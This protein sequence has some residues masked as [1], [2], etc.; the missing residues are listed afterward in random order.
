M[1]QESDIA[2]VNNKDEP[3]LSGPLRGALWMVLSAAS[4]AGLTTV[5][6]EVSGSMHPFELAFFRN[7]FGLMFMLPWLL[8][9]GAKVLKTERLSLHV[10]RSII[11]LGAMLCWFTAISMMPIAEATALS[12]STPLF[13]TIGAAV[14]LGESVRVRRWAATVA[15][16]IGALVIVRPSG[17][18]IG[19][20]SSLVLAA[21]AFMSMAALSIKSLSRTETPGTIVLFM[22]LIMTPMSLVPA[23]FHWTAPHLTDFP[24]FIALG[25]FATLGQIAMARA[26]A[27]ADVSTVLPFDFSRLIFAAILGY[28]FFAESPDIWTWVGAAII[29]SA[30]LYTAH[31]ESRQARLFRS[32]QATLVPAVVDKPPTD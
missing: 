6:R 14:F 16:L 25:L 10:F 30:A 13:A 20:A 18:D 11:G 12:F 7:L 9:V 1:T 4:F 3:G 8:R 22:G 17:I 19:F 29:F 23:L 31:R 26:F 24:W 32:V 28:L 15:G 27:S 21:S 5:I 2:E